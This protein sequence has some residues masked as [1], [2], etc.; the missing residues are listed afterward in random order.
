MF[1]IRAGRCGIAPAIALSIAVL[2]V[3]CR[4]RGGR[5]ID[6]RGA[7]AAAPAPDAAVTPIDAAAPAAPRPIKLVAAGDST[8]ALLANSTMQCWGGNA[9]GQLGNSTTADAARPVALD[10][11]AVKDLQLAGDTACA[12][13]DDASVA[14]WGR[15]GWHGHAEDVLRP[16]GVLGVIGVKQLFVVAGRACARVAND[17]LVCWGNVDARGQFAPG[18]T[19]RAPTPVV[20]VDHVAGLG[21][22]GAFS[23]DGRLWR[24]GADG[25][26]KLA[27]AAGVQELGDR[28]GGVCGRLA[29]GRVVC[30][31][32]DRCGP[33]HAGAGD[34]AGNAASGKPATAT[35]ASGATSGSGGGAGALGKLG[36]HATPGAAPASR[37]GKPSGLAKLGKPAKQPKPPP[38]SAAAPTD[39]STAVADPAGALGFAAAR[40]LAFGLGFC[41]VTTTHKLQCGDGCRTV[42]PPKLEHVDSVADRCA[43]LRSGAVTCLDHDKL[44]PVAG[45]A[46]ATS[47]AAG[48]AHAC[49]LVDDKIVCWSDDSHGQL[50]GFS[51]A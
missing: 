9:H 14:C 26:P 2:G 1:V 47:I 19:D 51:I 20:G 7:D 31:P 3:A 50:G 44:V 25:V 5:P 30:A 15:I 41:V 33:R 4:P 32:S 8:C 48:R 21:P 17:S 12:L 43:L 10:L 38:G 40:Q 13:L 27:Q 22:D 28:D 39:P 11:H 37:S 29:D 23:D 42:D 16:T 18:P 49:A 36:K 46:H 6:A 24:W 35:P 45:I 34:A